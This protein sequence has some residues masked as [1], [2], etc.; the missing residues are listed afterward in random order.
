MN[1]E[2]VARYKK[3]AAEA[4][5]RAGKATA[6]PWAPGFDSGLDVW[7][8]GRPVGSTQ[9]IAVTSAHDRRRATHGMAS[10]LANTAF[11]AAARTD[12]PDLAQAVL[13]LTAAYEHQKEALRLA[14]SDL[15]DA[16]RDLGQRRTYW[17]KP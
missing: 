16:V 15:A 4:L 11:I 10:R 5:E 9:I 7:E 13:A 8:A 17:N 2:D 12:V 1:S 14:H 3:L 6:G